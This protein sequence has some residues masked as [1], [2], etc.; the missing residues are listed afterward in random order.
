MKPKLSIII[1]CYNIEPHISKCVESILYQTFQDFELLLINDG[2]KDNTL[3]VCREYEQK[4]TRVKVYSHDNKGVSYTRNR[5]IELAQGE[6]ILFIDGD[7]YVKPDY[8]E[9]LVANYADGTWP[10]CGMI[11]IRK[12]K[13][14]E[15]EN[16]KKLLTLFPDKVV[17]KENIFEVM[18]HHSLSSPC[19]RVYSKTILAEKQII[20]PEDVTYQ[21]DLLFNLEYCKHI[22]QVR[23]LDYFGYYYIEHQ[24]SST[25]RYHKNFNHIDRLF[26]KLYK[27]VNNQN[28]EI[29]LQRFMF[30]TILK[31]L[32]N[33]FH[34]DAKHTY[35]EKLI[36]IDKVLQLESFKYIG[37]YIMKSKINVVYKAILKL[38]NKHILYLYLQI[39]AKKRLK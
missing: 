6:C 25:G 33:E 8:L 37:S 28:E 17:N 34:K 12:G 38:S 16:F 29:F 1:P 27:L 4:D 20:F 24:V 2:S 23:L 21:E 36:E 13:T 15:N 26:S 7:D 31:K 3:E 9:K 32:S 22:E 19:A 35:K 18:A 39:Y 14:K 11:N 5:G 10:I 30:D